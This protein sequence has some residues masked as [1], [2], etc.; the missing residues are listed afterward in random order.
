MEQPRDNVVEAF[1]LIELLAVIGVIALVAAVIFP[2]LARE[3][4]KARRIQCME[5]LKQL[6][7][8]FRPNPIDNGNRPSTQASTNREAALGYIA[9]GEAFRYFQ[10]MSNHLSV[11]KVLVCPADVRVPAKDFGPGLSNANLSYFVN[12][13]ASETYP[14]MV[15]YGDR[16]LTNGL[17]LQNGLLVLTSNSLVGWTHELHNLQGNLALADGSVQGIA[18]SRL[19]GLWA[20]TNRLAMP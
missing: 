8:S 1:T 3:K 18:N 6:G 2:A 11:P 16:N 12:L 19:S 4:Q 15:C 9:S 14:Q 17:P 7:V 13:N 10:A 20:G 5:N